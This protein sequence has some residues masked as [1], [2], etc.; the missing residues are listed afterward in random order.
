MFR[1]DTHLSRLYFIFT[2]G[3]ANQTMLVLY[4]VEEVFKSSTFSKQ[5][6]NL[7]IKTNCNLFWS[8]GE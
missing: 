2:Y 5:K 4:F 8:W 3:N 7:N 1:T 6:L